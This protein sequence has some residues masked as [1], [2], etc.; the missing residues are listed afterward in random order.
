[1]SASQPTLPSVC[2]V[3]PL[4]RVASFSNDERRIIAGQW[5]DML[6]QRMGTPG[7]PPG[8]DELPS[9]HDT[10][11]KLAAAS[12][13]VSTAVCS[14]PPSS[15]G[16]SASIVAW[17]A[18]FACERCGKI[19]TSLEARFCCGCG[20]SLRLPSKLPG[21]SQLAKTAPAPK[22]PALAELRPSPSGVRFGSEVAKSVPPEASRP[23]LARPLTPAAVAHVGASKGQGSASRG[24]GVA[25][26]VEAA[27]VPESAGE[28]QGEGARK[29][30]SKKPRAGRAALT[31][32]KEAIP[33]PPRGQKRTSC[34]IPITTLGQRERQ[35][36]NWVH[37][38]KPRKY[39]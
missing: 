12:G 17:F 13:K 39:A 27:Q 15:I 33:P 6:R 31:A 9:L 19:P 25:G 7:Q 8:R 34:P 3:Q 36:A 23:S 37:W 30:D 4:R 38:V 35:M 20:E 16:P 14:V 22:L 28:K 18:Q 2:S 21:S 24:P 32:P 10:R 29:G 1:M 26:S 5:D 11:R